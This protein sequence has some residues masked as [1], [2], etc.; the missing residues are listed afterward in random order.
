MAGVNIL[1]GRRD[2]L[3]PGAGR[4]A[5]GAGRRTTLDNARMTGRKV[6]LLKVR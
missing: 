4:R 1:I 5:P 6:I 2:H 3:P